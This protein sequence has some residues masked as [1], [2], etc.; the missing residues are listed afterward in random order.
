MY[1][2]GTPIRIWSAKRFN[3]TY[4]PYQCREDDCPV[5]A[6]Y[7]KRVQENK[8][9]KVQ[10]QIPLGS[11]FVYKLTSNHTSTNLIKR[12]VRKGGN[13]LR[14]S[15]IDII[16][17]ISDMLDNRVAACDIDP[18][19]LVSISIR[20]DWLKRITNGTKNKQTD[21]IN[22]NVTKITSNASKLVRDR[23]YSLSHLLISDIRSREASEIMQ[24]LP[25][26]ESKLLLMSGYTVNHKESIERSSSS[27]EIQ[28]SITDHLNKANEMVSSN[29][30]I[31]IISYIKAIKRFD[32]DFMG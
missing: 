17:V 29:D 20:S 18:F 7:N 10:S 19:D 23:I 25:D 21:E 15:G 2:C 26:R 24:L 30:I 6:L 31:S 27:S 5:C 3:W 14:L 28:D 32:K 9:L 1:K 12:I 11:I 13:Y 22:Y 16:Y 8:I 4:Y